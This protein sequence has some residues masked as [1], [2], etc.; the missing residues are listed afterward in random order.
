MELHQLEYVL[1]LEKY[2]KF[3]LAAEKISVSQSNLSD[4]IK[5]LE[6]ELGVQLFE[7]TTRK[8]EL[9]Y[10]GEKFIE[11]A[12]RIINEVE[13]AKHAMLEFSNGETARIRIGAY[14][15]ITYLGI[16]SMIAKFQK[17]YPG[18]DIE[19]TEANSDELFIK[20]NSSEIDMAFLT[21]PYI[22]N[23]NYSFYPLIKDKLVLFV[24]KENKLAQKKTIRFADLAN[25]KF[26]LI[27]STT[28]FQNLIVQHCLNAGFQPNIILKSSLVET[29][30][31]LVEENMGISLFSKRVADAIVSPKTTI[32]NFETEEKRIT[33]LVIPKNQENLYGIQT[34][35]DFILQQKLDE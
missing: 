29:I 7:R 4:Q 27:N 32:V 26:L 17:Q 15:T 11:Y 9:T 31:Q 33:G 22:G 16:T 34:F 18:Y 19:I 23:L 8:V 1:A 21:F 2:M 6:A 28:A 25:E 35:R 3:S 13:N 30:K 20:L 12:K 5:K 24:S 14:S 10:A